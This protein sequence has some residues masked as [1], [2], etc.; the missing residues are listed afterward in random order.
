MAEANAL[1]SKQ[2]TIAAEARIETRRAKA[3]SLRL[4][5]K[6]Y[7]AI[8]KETGVTVRQAWE[9]VKAVLERT[10]ADANE[11][12][13][14]H[15]AIDLERIDR[16]IEVCMQALDSDE[17]SFGAIDRLVKLQERRA[18][19]LGLDSPEKHAVAVAD[20]TPGRAREI[21]AELFG[22]V[23]PDKVDAPDP[24]G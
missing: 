18:K 4:K 19:L 20:A 6:T 13:E 17:Q 21:M 7:R 10:K 1:T 16:A 23:T 12:A 22:A 14:H 3:I 5:G 24:A 9:D 15:R 2:E 8:A 11:D